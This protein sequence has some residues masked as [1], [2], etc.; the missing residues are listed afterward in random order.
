MRHGRGEYTYP[1]G[2]KYS[3]EQYNDKK[4]GRGIFTEKD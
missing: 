2:E 1:N 4:E 3:G